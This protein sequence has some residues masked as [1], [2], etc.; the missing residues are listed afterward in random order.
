MR[1]TSGGTGNARS[2]MQ[3]NT[4]PVHLRRRKSATFNTSN[5][6][7]PFCHAHETRTT[8]TDPTMTTAPLKRRTVLSASLATAVTLAAGV[9]PAQAN[10]DAAALSHTQDIDDDDIP[11]H[12]ARFHAT[13]LEWLPSA[14]ARLAL[15]VSVVLESPSYTRIDI[16]GINPALEIGFSH[17]ANL[18][19]WVQWD[20]TCWDALIDWDTSAR[21]VSGGWVNTLLLKEY[22]DVHPTLEALWRSGPLEPMVAW[23]NDELAHA[24]HIAAWGDPGSATWAYLAR[25]GRKLASNKLLATSG[26]YKPVHLLPLH[27]HRA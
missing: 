10:T 26:R 14:S 25:N 17:G 12:H 18:I 24:T 15:P 6:D 19:A 11:D 22:Q 9:D 13:L 16:D 3:E 27:G 2:A 7:A 4:D 5:P 8:E 21:Q 23:V 1:R 20:G